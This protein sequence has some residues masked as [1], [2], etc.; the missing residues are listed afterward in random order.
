M[1]KDGDKLMFL[2]HTSTDSDTMELGP[3]EKADAIQHK[4]L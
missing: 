1:Y 3:N 4:V 2:V